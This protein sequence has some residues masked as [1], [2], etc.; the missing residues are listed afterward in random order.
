MW[1]GEC[2]TSHPTILFHVKNQEKF[3]ESEVAEGETERVQCAWGKKHRAP[4]EYL[5]GQDGD[6]LM[7]PF[8]CDLCVF[9]ELK[10]FEPS[11]EFEEDKLLL[12]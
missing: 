2:Y 9:R 8:E 3:E 5:V 4:D 11:S 12:A 6:R 1:C 10:N 7:V